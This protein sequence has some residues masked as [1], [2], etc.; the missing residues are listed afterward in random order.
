MTR[1]Y[2]WGEKSERVDEYVPDV[3]FER[4]SIIATLGTEGINAPMTYKG[5]L[6]GDVFRPYVEQVLAPTLKAGD[7]VIMDNYS[8]HKVG[9]I[10][11]PIYAKGAVVL[12]LP[13]YSPDLNPIEMAWSKIKS[14]L[15]KLKPRNSED[16]QT[17]MKTALD[18]ITK[19]DVENWFKYNGYFLHPECVNV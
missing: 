16:M 15:R 19:T 14:I 6:N 8:V 12:F 9:G 11:D 1:L 7:I 13:P 17:A 10:L 4:S 3:R 2:G 18:A 5:T